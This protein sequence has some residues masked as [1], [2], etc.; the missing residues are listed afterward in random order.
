MSNPMT[1]QHS[2]PWSSLHL[3]SSRR[4]EIETVHNFFWVL[5]DQGRIGLKVNF[6]N[7]PHQEAAIGK[8]R[9]INVI[10]RQDEHQSTELY[11]IISS[12]ADREIFHSL[13]LDLIKSTHQIPGSTEMYECILKR[14][15][16]WQRFLSQTAA[17]TLPEQLQM[18]LYAELLFLRDT[19]MTALPPEA[20]LHTW[21]GPD[22]D[23]QD[24]SFQACLTEIKAFITSK[25]PFVRISSLHQLFFDD[26][27]LYLI[28]FGISRVSAGA[29]VVT[30]ISE[31]RE[32]LTSELEHDLFDQKLAQYGYF[33]GIT[34]EP[35]FTYTADSR[36]IY[37]ISTEFPRIVPDQIPNSI[38][39]VQYSIDL[40][41]CQSFAADVLPIINT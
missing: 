3:S 12:N 24:F 1:E 29:S 18:G 41:K 28:A 11:L 13:S 22:F 34:E 36:R 40:S 10:V 9:G 30:L 19:V 23:K 21:V 32:K 14:L 38:M 25:G 2:N 16:H 35:F 20:A 4:V 5:D 39:N 26:K 17:K 31:I 15:R 33:E 6:S 37:M 7:L 8:I 27:P